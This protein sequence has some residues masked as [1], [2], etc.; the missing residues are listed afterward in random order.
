MAVLGISLRTPQWTEDYLNIVPVSRSG[1]HHAPVPKICTLL[2]TIVKIY[3]INYVFIYIYI[4]LLPSFQWLKHFILHN[5][6]HEI[7]QC[8]EAIV[9][10]AASPKPT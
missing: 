4:H 8:G 2:R 1:F 6:F 9:Y 3:L 10:Q 7:I 5:P